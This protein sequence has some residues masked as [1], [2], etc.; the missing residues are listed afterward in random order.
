VLACVTAVQ[1]TLIVFDEVGALHAA[2]TPVGAEGA[3]D[4]GDSPELEACNVTVQ[5]VAAHAALVPDAS[6]RPTSAIG[7]AARKGP[8]LVCTWAPSPVA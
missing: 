4:D 7:A 1:L 5:F 2:V 8:H 6:R 3:V